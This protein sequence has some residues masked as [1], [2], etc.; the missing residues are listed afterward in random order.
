[1]PEIRFTVNEDFIDHLKKETGID[2]A[3]QLTTEALS[4]LQ[5]AITETK[6]GRMLLS[7]DEKGGDAR[8]VVMPSLERA[9]AFKKEK[10]HVKQ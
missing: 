8:R 4:L 7:V 1:M 6:N 3:S 9:R 10:E 5:W 2:K